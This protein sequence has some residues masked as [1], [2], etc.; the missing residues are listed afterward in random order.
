[1]PAYHTVLQGSCVKRQCVAPTSEF[2]TSTIVTDVE[3]SKQY[4]YRMIPSGT[5]YIQSSVVKSMY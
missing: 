5:T 1:M 3:E 4:K 2:Y